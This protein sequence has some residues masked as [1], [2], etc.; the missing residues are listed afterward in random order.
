MNKRQR[1]KRRKQ[2]EVRLAEPGDIGAGFRAMLP[3]PPVVLRFIKSLGQWKD[4]LGIVHSVN[5]LA[6]GF[7]TDI[8]LGRET[9]C[10]AGYWNPDETWLY[11]DLVSD[12]INCMACVAGGGPE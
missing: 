2:Q 7:D 8:D 4:G 3:G 1:N 10:G 11:P 9:A 12:E 5:A 6:L